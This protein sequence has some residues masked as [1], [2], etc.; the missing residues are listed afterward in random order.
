MESH[1]TTGLVHG[2]AVFAH[3]F[4]TRCVMSPLQVSPS[5]TMKTHPL[6][7]DLRSLDSLCKNDRVD[8]A[9]HS[10]GGTPIDRW[11]VYEEKSHPWVM[12]WGTPMT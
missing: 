5:S 10:H 2:Q 11:L 3:F 4:G 9:F 1:S 8:I 7:P 12:T 6:T